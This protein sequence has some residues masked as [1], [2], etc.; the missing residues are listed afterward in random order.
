M[1]SVNMWT[2][3]GNRLRIIGTGGASV[4]PEQL[5][6][7]IELVGKGA[8]RGPVIDRELPLERAAEAHRLIE[9]RETF[10]KVVLRP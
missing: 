2:V 8:L 10:G 9:N 4:T 6:Q 5:D 1:V 3:V 7:L